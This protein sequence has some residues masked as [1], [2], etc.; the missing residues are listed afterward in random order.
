LKK[1]GLDFA[2]AERVFS[3]RTQ[4]F[5]DNHFAYGEMR[6]ITVGLLGDSVVVIAHTE[7]DKEIR[8][9]SMPKALRHERELYF[10]NC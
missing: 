9:I 4:S 8:I 1:H 5:P 10:A 7:S 6:F 3:G 2:D